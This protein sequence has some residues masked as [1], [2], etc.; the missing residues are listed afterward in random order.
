M[1]QEDGSVC[2]LHKVT[3]I[4]PTFI[5]IEIALHTAYIRHAIIAFFYIRFEIVLFRETYGPMTNFDAQFLKNYG[6]DFK[7]DQ[8]RIS[9]SSQR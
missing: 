2:R 6:T 5:N 1:D 9:A 8:Y 3:D 4:E 7:S